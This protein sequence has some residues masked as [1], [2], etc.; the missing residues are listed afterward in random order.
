MEQEFKDKFNNQIKLTGKQWNHIIKEHPEVEPCK[1]RLSEVLS[2]RRPN[3][4][5]ETKISFYTT[6]TIEIYTKENIYW[7]LQKQ[8]KNQ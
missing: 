6:A 2:K 3:S 4:S 1:N 5:K 7:L 8:R